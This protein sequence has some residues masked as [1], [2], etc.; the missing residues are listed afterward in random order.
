MMNHVAY[1]NDQLRVVCYQLSTLLAEIIDLRSSP[2]SAHKSSIVGTIVLLHSVQMMN[3]VA[4]RND[5]LRKN[6]CKAL[7]LSN[8]L[9]GMQQMK[10]QL[11]SIKDS[12]C[13]NL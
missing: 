6:V 1:R 10:N 3:Q 2:P 12:F 8:R 7:E 5:Q 9:R 11:S 13:P 4:Y